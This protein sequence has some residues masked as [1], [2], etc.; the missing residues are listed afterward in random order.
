MASNT[1]INTGSGEITFNG[2]VDG[3]RSLTLTN[4]GTTR[5]T[6]AVGSATPL[7]D[8]TIDGGGTIQLAVAGIS[9]PNSATVTTTG[10][11]AYADPITLEKPTFLKS[12]GASV[13]LAYAPV[14]GGNGFAT[15]NGGAAGC[16]SM[17]GT[18]SA[19]GSMPCLNLLGAVTLNATGALTFSGLVDGAY[20]LTLN[21]NF[22]KIF[23][24]QVGSV[25]RLASL[26]SNGAGTTQ[27]VGAETTGGVIT[28]GGNASLSGNY[29][30]SGGNF[31]VTGATTLAGDTT[32]S[33]GSGTISF[34]GTV[35]GAHALSTTNTASTTFNDAVG[36][37]SAL[38]TLSASAGSLNAAQAI[39]T[40]GAVSL[41]A[42]TIGLKSLAAGGDVALNGATT[43]DGSYTTSN[44]A[45]T[46]S[47]ATTLASDTSVSTGSGA[48]RFDGTVNGAHALSTTNTASTTFNDA[49]GNS[50]ALTTLSA[51]AGSLNAAQAINTSGAVSLTAATIGLKSLAAGGDVALNGATTLDGSYTTSNDAFTVSGA[52]T[53][54][55]DT[56][57]STGS[58]AIRF[59][60]TVNG[61]HALS[62]TNTAS[63]TF[64]DAVGNS[65]ALT[66]LSAS[67]GSLNAAQAINTSGAVSLTA[68]TIG[69]KSLAAGGDVALNGATTLDGSYT[70]SNDAFTVSG[71]TTLASDTSVSTG[72]GAIR[73]DG[74]VNGAHALSTTTTA[75][76]TLSGAVGSSNALK[77]LEISGPAILHGVTTSGSQHYGST[78]V[79]SNAYH[80]SKGVIN[81]DGVT[82]LE[83]DVTVAANDITIAGPFDGRHVV[84]LDATANLNINGAIGVVDAPTSLT[85]S[86][87]NQINLA[88]GTV[89]TRSDQRWNGAVWLNADTRVVSQDA[90][91]LV[92]NGAVD[93][94][95]AASLSAE[96]AGATRFFRPLGV[97]GALG[98]LSTDFAGTSDDKTEFAFVTTSGPSVRAIGNIT[99]RDAV[100]SN[101]A[102][103]LVAGGQLSATNAANKWAASGDALNIDA[104]RADVRSA[105]TLRLGTI[106]LR[107][108]GEIIGEKEIHLLGNLVLDGGT[109][110]LTSNAAPNVL[111]TYSDPALTKRAAQAGVPLLRFGAAEL[112]EYTAVISQ[113][114]D[115]TITTAEGSLLALRSS[116]GGSINLESAGNAVHGGVSAVSG[117]IGGPSRFDQTAKTIPVSFVRLSSDQLNIEG[118]PSG[119]SAAASGLLADAVK[120]TGARLKTGT[121]G[122]IKAR[123]PYIDA[124]GVPTSMPGVVFEILPA[125]LTAQ[126]FG[127]PSQGD[128]IRIQIGDE[129]RGGFV[130]LNPKG[131]FRPDFAVFAGGSTSQIPFYDGTNV[132]TEIQIFYNGAL[133]QSA[134]LVGALT[135]V[136]A[137]A[138]DARRQKIEDSVRTENVTRRL[139]SGVIA[140]VGP[141]R[142]ATTDIDGLRRP[143]V[144][145]PDAD[146]LSCK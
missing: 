59:D 29:A 137:V 31:G 3:A 40:S 72:S 30:T 22:D 104:N 42:A 52:T 111:D 97:S 16:D 144:C 81:F 83:S 28:I 1:T 135:A 41:T 142:P 15:R 63:T 27:L 36:N 21:G 70:T 94:A 126:G 95:N 123:L 96:T 105:A 119:G 98:S 101:G 35:N 5:L 2:T 11:Q 99:L 46:V 64:N 122:L 58:G 38:T 112:L 78:A 80:A 118:N 129:G 53:L 91:S 117:A 143:E 86:A 24:A 146:S 87:G 120:L 92:F 90:G 128:W 124:Q 145:E 66:T 23:N 25:T 74:T 49:V 85:A 54:A 56:S 132:S 67:A 138:E 17:V 93:S 45:F 55:S 7:S 4:S 61:A 100:I 121:G 60:G 141:G 14:T 75:S 113:D 140:E 13:V 62:T 32:I 34:S 39:N 50:S 47:G 114:A 33:T 10:N 19:S 79:L 18:F 116:A 136:S 48:I 133:P 108:G 65:S 71:A 82:T 51:S 8:L 12:T 44:D 69:L 9:Y 107:N 6:G 130:T 102:V 127:S 134:N 76:T 20:A 57:V 68:A 115:S 103:S 43:L 139:R 89:S 88:G 73:F 26:T 37:S 109:L 131:A 110:V 77:T 106:H 84:V 125:A